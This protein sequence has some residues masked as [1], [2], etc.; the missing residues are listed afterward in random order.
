M[1]RVKWGGTHSCMHAIKSYLCKVTRWARNG[2]SCTLKDEITII[3]GTSKYFNHCAN[4]QIWRLKNQRFRRSHHLNRRCLSVVPISRLKT[5]E[6]FGIRLWISH[7]ITIAIIL[8]LLCS[9][10]VF[11]LC[12]QL[13]HLCKFSTTPALSHQCT[14]LPSLQFYSQL[15]PVHHILL[16]QVPS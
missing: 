14:A 4:I 6:K 12:H 10:C 13:P 11:V 8:I 5:V 1:T 7:F 2:S 15:A 3:L 9:G 16:N